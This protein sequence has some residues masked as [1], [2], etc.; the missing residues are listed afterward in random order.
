[1]TSRRAKRVL[2]ATLVGV[3]ILA[4]LVTAVGRFFE[5]RALARQLEI[6]RG[7]IRIPQ[8]LA[9]ELQPR[10]L[11]RL[12]TFSARL[13]PWA[14]ARLGPEVAGR[15]QQV[16]VDVG[17]RF[18]RGDTLVELDPALAGLAV[19][20]AQERDD[21]AGRRLRE[22][23][24]LVASQAIAGTDLESLRSAARL[25]RIEL[26][27]AREHLARHAITAPFDGS[28][29]ARSAD[30]G[31]MVS[32]GE[33][34][35]VAVEDARL[36]VVFFVNEMEIAAFHVGAL[37]EVRT[38]ARPAE[39]FEARVHLVGTA[40][41]GATGLVQVEAE[42][43]NAGPQLPANAS[44]SVRARVRLYE[45]T[46]FAPAGGV[47]FDGRQAYVGRLGADGAVARVDIEIGPEIDG[48]FPVVRGLAAGDRIVLR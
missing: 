22:A 23:E 19:E 8:P 43:D 29:L 44:A 1:M 25:A 45:D 11:E 20:A 34:L 35:L 14:E 15:V 31:M 42:L 24:A 47:R 18:R 4:A 21:D 37:V 36:R 6:E 39:A 38:P 9:V 27:R 3:F 28:V 5:A 16:R 40:A 12:R 7:Q 17:A 32:P 48:M 26:S 13:A 30:V 46:L 33:P 10:A 41:D 2:L